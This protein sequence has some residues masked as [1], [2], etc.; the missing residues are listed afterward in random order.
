M[1]LSALT[2]LVQQSGAE[3]S[4]LSLRRGNKNH[5]QVR[6]SD[7]QESLETMQTEAWLIQTQANTQ[8][9]R[10]SAMEKRGRQKGKSN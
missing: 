4:S 10:D 5:F 1:K 3:W 6:W 2:L 7:R 9:E 8:L